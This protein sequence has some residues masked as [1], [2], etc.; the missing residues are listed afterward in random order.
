MKVALVCDWLTEIGGAEKVLLNLH[1]IYPKAPI[2]TS[3]YD[4]KKI[5]WFKDADVRTTWLSKLPKSLKKFLPVLRAWSFSRL[6]L[7]EYDLVISSSGAEAKAVKTGSNTIHICY[8]HSPTQYYWTRQDEYLKTPGFPKGFNWIAKISLKILDKPL[9]AWDKLA[10]KKP[11]YIITN[12]EYTKSMIKKF[13]NRE[14][15]VIHPPVEIN[16]FKPKDFANL[17]HG[18]VIAGRQTPYKRF[19]LAIKACNRLKIPLIVIGNGPEHK[20]LLKIAKKSITFLTSVN[21]LTLVEQFQS[22]L[23]FIFPGKDDFGIVAVEALAAGTPVIAYK[24]GGALDYLKN[25]K[26]GIFFNRQTTE[27]LTKAIEEL[28]T[29]KFNYQKVYESSLAFSEEVFNQKIRTFI[30]DVLN[31]S[32]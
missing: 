29:R 14:A 5:D 22:A 19:D 11:D 23:G 16:K 8:L 26:N 17:R 21:D 12:S 2:Y 24:Q 4:P 31:K 28:T 27:N 1:Q 3:Q 18:L 10:A 13:Y 20:K 7:S 9:K 6:D 25:K 32:K 30:K 15:T